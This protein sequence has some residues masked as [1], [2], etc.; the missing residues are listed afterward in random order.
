MK[1]WAL[2][3]D[4]AFHNYI[5]LRKKSRRILLKIFPLSV[6]LHFFS[7]LSIFFGGIRWDISTIC[8]KGCP[9]L[10][11][12]WACRGGWSWRGSAGL[13]P[14]RRLFPSARSF[15]LNKRFKQTVSAYVRYRL[16]F[17]HNR[18]ADGLNWGPNIH[19]N[20][21]RLIRQSPHLAHTMIARTQ[22]KA[23]MWHLGR[24]RPPYDFLVLKLSHW[25]H[26]Y[27]CSH[28]TWLG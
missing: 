17:V 15:D 25:R 11:R 14:A 23:N 2:N 3:K 12:E 5:L 16:P 6:K 20:C 27:R 18:A 1:R 10:W 8:G 26:K 19:W 7:G 4:A 21:N 22:V 24:V 28:L 9:V 13:C